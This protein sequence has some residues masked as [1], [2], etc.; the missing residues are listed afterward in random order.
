MIEQVLFETIYI[1]QG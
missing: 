1:L